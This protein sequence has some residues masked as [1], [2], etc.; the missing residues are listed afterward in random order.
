[1]FIE[2]KCKTI[3]FHVRQSNTKVSSW[4]SRENSQDV[5]EDFSSK[6]ELVP[7][8]SDGYLDAG[9]ALLGGDLFVVNLISTFLEV[10]IFLKTV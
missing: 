7:L 1:M 8:G 3:K 6:R 10:A 2:P 4:L 9:V 5:I